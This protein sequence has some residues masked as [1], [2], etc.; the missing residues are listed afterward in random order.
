MK[1]SEARR[2]LR[3]MVR[4]SGMRYAL[5]VKPPWYMGLAYREWHSDHYIL[6]PIP[7]NFVVRYARE[8]WYLLKNGGSWPRALDEAYFAGYR[9]AAAKK[10]WNRSKP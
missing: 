10:P 8:L 3:E 4:W 1:W 5:G 6:L 7:V 2:T 9:D